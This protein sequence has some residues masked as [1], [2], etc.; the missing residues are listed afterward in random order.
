M[1][2]S[3]NVEERNGHRDELAGEREKDLSFDRWFPSVEC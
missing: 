3:V 2:L 1:V